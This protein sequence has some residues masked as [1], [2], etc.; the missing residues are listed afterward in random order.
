MYKKFCKVTCQAPSR[1]FAVHLFVAHLSNTRISHVFIRPQLNLH[2]DSLR[3]D[4][5]IH[6]KGVLFLCYQN[7]L[8]LIQSFQLSVKQD[9]IFTSGS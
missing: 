2:Q 1:V 9:V 6:G 4:T 5:N 7:N 3:C 8:H